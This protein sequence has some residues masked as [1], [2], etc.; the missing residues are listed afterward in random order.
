[1]HVQE[2]QASLSHVH[3]KSYSFTVSLNQFLSVTPSLSGIPMETYVYPEA[4]TTSLHQE[5]KYFI[6]EIQ[7]CSSFYNQATTIQPFYFSASGT[8]F[9]TWHQNPLVL[10]LC[11]LSRLPNNKVLTPFMTWVP[12]ACPVEYQSYHIYTTLYIFP[13]FLEQ[14]IFL[15]LVTKESMFCITFPKCIGL[16][17]FF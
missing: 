12:T 2:S 14:V 6:R 5:H 3:A 10:A 4:S 16:F 15:W 1:M 17:F 11:W 7:N 8:C 13:F 9:Q